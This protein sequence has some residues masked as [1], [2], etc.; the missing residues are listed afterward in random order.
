MARRFDIEYDDFSGGHYVGPQLANQPRNTWVG[1]NVAATADDG[2]LVADPGWQISDVIHSITYPTP[3]S[4]PDTRHPVVINPFPYRAPFPLSYMVFTLD[5]GTK[6]IAKVTFSGGGTIWTLPVAVA[7]ILAAPASHPGGLLTQVPSSTGAGFESVATV[8][9]SNVIRF[10]TQGT[11]ESTVA[12]SGRE[13]ALWVWQ[14]W[15]ITTGD[16]AIPNRL[17]FSAPN[18]YT[19]WPTNNFYDIGPAFTRIVNVVPTADALYVHTFDGWYIL[20]GVLGETASVRK[21]SRFAPA[22][23]E[24]NFPWYSGVLTQRGI[25]QR[26]GVG[27][28][29]QLLNGTRTVPIMFLPDGVT[30]RQIVNAGQHVMAVDSLARV[31]LW[32]EMTESWRCS[33]L[34]TAAAFTAALA[35]NVRYYAARD[36]G[37]FTELAALV[38]QPYN[39]VGEKLYGVVQPK[40]LTEPGVAV[41]ANTHTTATVKLADTSQTQ[42]FKVQDVLVEV[43]FGNPR[44]QTGSRSLGCRVI[45]SPVIDMAAGFARTVNG[46]PAPSASQ[47]Q[48]VSWSNA[49]STK[50]GDRQLVRFTPNDLPPTYTAAPELTI[51]GVKVRRVIMRCEAI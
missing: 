32:S 22:L 47:L 4:S 46:N 28:V 36:E 38:A 10:N 37:N 30:I 15:G 34:P 29:L 43:D 49:T 7:S 16:I 21:V 11:V 18:N 3:G 51:Q 19:S 33:C 1:E 5:D 48:T 2:Y 41:G 42:P 23:V 35:S 50:N 45:A 39:Y 8:A 9:G 27:D 17:H 12:L 40:E 20:T 26:S 13:Q 24:T 44:V 31:W 6:R 14:A 25:V